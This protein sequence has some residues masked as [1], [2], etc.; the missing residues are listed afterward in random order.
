L[1]KNWPENILRNIKRPETVAEAVD[2]LMMV[3]DGEQKIALAVMPEGDLIDLHFTL[4]MAI[5][6]AFGLHDPWSKL[7]V[8]C[9]VVHSDDASGVIIRELWMRFV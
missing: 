9:G 6:N 7:L 2:R 4:G 1:T 5:R 3:L 8:S